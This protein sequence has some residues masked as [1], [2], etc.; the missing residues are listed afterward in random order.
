MDKMRR[1]T[2][3]G[4]LKKREFDLM[5]DFP[6]IEMIERKTNHPKLTLY[7]IFSLFLIMSCV[8]FVSSIGDC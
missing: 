1:P 6:F 3:V 7:R 2:T 5:T 4:R 8:V